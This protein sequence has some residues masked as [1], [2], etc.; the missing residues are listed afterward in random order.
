MHGKRLSFVLAIWFVSVAVGFGLMLRLQITPNVQVDAADLMPSV[1]SIVTEA[2]TPTLVMFLHP[3]CPCSR[4][5]IAELE[6]LRARTPEV[7]TNIVSISQD[8]SWQES[9]LL[10][11]V[12]G[13]DGIHLVTDT[14]GR[15]ATRF[16]ARTSGETFLY[17]A[18]GALLFHGGITQ[19]RG[20][21]GENPGSS[22]IFAL[23]H[24]QQVSVPRSEVFGCPLF[25]AAM[26]GPLK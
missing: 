12:S 3:M 20:H 1:D 2:G 11:Q 6:R 9:N 4:A 16:N 14:E 15:I 5:S 22:A 10:R 23:L 26:I 24:G 8:A 18:E 25:S 17:E 19:G 7:T 13:L 21:E